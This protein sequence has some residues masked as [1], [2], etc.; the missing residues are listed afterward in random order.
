MRTAQ[1]KYSKRRQNVAFFIAMA[2]SVI[3]E[4]VHSWSILMEYLGGKRV[5]PTAKGW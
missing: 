1:G 3:R 2:I 5:E 4:K